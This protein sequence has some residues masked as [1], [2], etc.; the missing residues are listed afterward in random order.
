MVEGAPPLN[1]VQTFRDQDQQ[2]QSQ[3]Y[4]GGAGVVQQET[5]I[6]SGG[7]GVARQFPV[8]NGGGLD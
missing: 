3:I 4:T 2:S 5:Q 6:S 7:R 8:Q 1:A